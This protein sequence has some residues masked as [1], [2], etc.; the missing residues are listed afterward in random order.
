MKIKQIFAYIGVIILLPPL[1]V[2]ALI[3][4]IMT[5]TYAVFT[6]GADKLYDSLMGNE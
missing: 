4:A 3:A 1:W 2:V 6:E 5:A